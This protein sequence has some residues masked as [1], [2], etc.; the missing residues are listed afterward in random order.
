MECHAGSCIMERDPSAE[1]PRAKH[2]NKSQA[3]AWRELAEEAGVKPVL[4]A[5]DAHPTVTGVQLNACAVL[6]ELAACPPGLKQLQN[7]GARD[8]LL[9]ATQ[10]HPFN[11]ELT[12]LAEETMHYLPV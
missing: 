6:K 5:M 8:A 11:Q 10:R 7:G 12:K 2:Q 3:A 9:A 4:A 1:A